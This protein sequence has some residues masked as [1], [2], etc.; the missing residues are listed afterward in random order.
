M[1]P[2]AMEIINNVMTVVGLIIQCATLITLII[3]LGRALNKPNRTQ[4]GRL[5]ALESWRST[6]EKRLNDGSDHFDTIDKGM[7]ITQEALLA[8]MSHAIN[9]NDI[10]KLRE[11]K[12]KL[13]NY[14]I[15]K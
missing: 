2:A 6:V 5:D 15:E 13:E 4:D 8:L 3:T 12:N 1:E 9:G 11:A 10:D 14:L 7:R